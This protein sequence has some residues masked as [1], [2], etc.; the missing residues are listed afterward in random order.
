MASADMDDPWLPGPS[1]ARGLGLAWSGVS[2]DQLNISRSRLHTEFSLF[3]SS[4]FEELTDFSAVRES[5]PQIRVRKSRFRNCSSLSLFLL[6]ER[7]AQ[8]E[9]IL[10]EDFQG[11]HMLRA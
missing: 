8:R 1:A 11:S 10:G 4:R 9:S 5:H 3:L 6:F 2:H 7:I